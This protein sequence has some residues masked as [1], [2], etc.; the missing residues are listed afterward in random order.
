MS[1]SKSGTT[2]TTITT[3]SGV[4]AA[5]INSTNNTSQ[6]NSIANNSSSHS[7]SVSES[8]AVKRSPLH[9]NSGG[10]HSSCVPMQRSKSELKPQP[11]KRPPNSTKPVIGRMVEL[12]HVETKE[13][14]E[15]KE[16]EKEGTTVS[17][18]PKL[19]QEQASPSVV[20]ASKQSKQQQKQQDEIFISAP[21]TPPAPPAPNG[22][23]S[24]TTFFFF[25]LFSLVIYC[26]L[27]FLGCRTVSHSTSAAQ[28]PAPPEGCRQADEL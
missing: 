3:S 21:L 1:K 8:S 24:I 12:R 27:L 16:R 11:P 5:M 20:D 13:E 14:R 7:L 9:A 22:A 28:V 18:A 2:T 4:A 26:P 25:F 23:L 17:D 10:S 15:R 6:N 19:K